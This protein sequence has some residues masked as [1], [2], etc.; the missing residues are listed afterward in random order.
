M[1]NNKIVLALIGIV[2]FSAALAAAG[3]QGS[4]T[5][6]GLPLFALCASV[7][8]LLHWLAFIPA[9]LFQTERYFDLTGGVSFIGTVSL[10][11]FLHPAMS[12]RGWLLCLLVAVWAARLSLFLFHRIHKTGRD[13]RFDTMKSRFWRFLLTWTLAGAW[14]FVTLAAAL[15]AITQ[16]DSG[17]VDGFLIAGALI[18]ALGFAFEVIADYQKSAFR[19]DPANADKFISTGLWAWSRHPNY[20]GE[21]VLWSGIA[22]IAIPALQGW[23]WLTLI[24]PLFVTLLL[25]RISGVP[26]LEDSAE[27]RWGNDPEYQ[28]YVQRTPVLIPRP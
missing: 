25:T 8:F 5:V 23:Q 13:R 26:M 14:V 16:T 15:A 19:A 17:A 7:G 9:Y 20:F 28:R 2:G 12:V 3:S 22:I 21:I 1:A 6:A 4:I 10:A 27:K 18:W 11:A 24:S